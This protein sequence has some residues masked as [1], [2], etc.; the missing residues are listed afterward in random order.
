M[1]S[2]H[3]AHRVH[4]QGQHVQLS[5]WQ[6]C[7]ISQSTTVQS[8]NQPQYSTISQSIRAREAQ[9]SI[10]HRRRGT[11]TISQI[12]ADRCTISQ[13]TTVKSVNQ[14]QPEV[15]QSIVH[16]FRNTISQTS[17]DRGTISQS[18][19]IQPKSSNHSQRGTTVDYPQTEG[20]QYN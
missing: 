5:P 9:Q 6:R 18:T 13:S 1:E 14:L 8:V 4:Q 7:T 19:T 17:T 20:Y 16:R 15:Q 2:L 3:G 11:S 10:I 12:Y